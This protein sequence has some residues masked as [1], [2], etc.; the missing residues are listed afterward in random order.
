MVA[1]SVNPGFVQVAPSKPAAI[2]HSIG[3]Y[4]N[5]CDGETFRNSY[6]ESVH[7]KEQINTLISEKCLK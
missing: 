7:C 1:S 6:D 5:K 2:H 4:L 3:K